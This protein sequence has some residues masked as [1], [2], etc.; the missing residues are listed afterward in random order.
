MKRL[1]YPKL[2][3]C[4][5]FILFFWANIAAGLSIEDNTVRP[6]MLFNG[7]NLAQIKKELKE[8]EKA[9]GKEEK[10]LDAKELSKK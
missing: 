6:Q 2:L 1:Q 8:Q 3:S 7:D 5:I 10:A 9:A 4:V